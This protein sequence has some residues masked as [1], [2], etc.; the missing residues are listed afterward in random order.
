MCDRIHTDAVSDLPIL[1][2]LVKYPPAYDGP[3]GDTLAALLS[4]VASAMHRQ[5]GDTVSELVAMIEELTG[6]VI[7]TSQRIARCGDPQEKELLSRGLGVYAV[8]VSAAALGI[9]FRIDAAGADVP[10]EPA[11]AA[12][13]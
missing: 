7:V 2:E 9:A 13:G 4:E 10:A 5:E 3:A 11:E 1:A 12:H 6:D 8:S